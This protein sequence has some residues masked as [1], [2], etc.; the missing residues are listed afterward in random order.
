MSFMILSLALQD[1]R[2]GWRGLASTFSHVKKT[3]PGAS[4]FTQYLATTPDTPPDSPDREQYTE[5]PSDLPEEGKGTPG[6]YVSLTKKDYPTSQHIHYSPEDVQRAWFSRYHEMYQ[7]V[8]LREIVV[9]RNVRMIQD[10]PRFLKVE[11]S[12]S[13]KQAHGEDITEKQ[14]MLYHG[15]GLEF[16]T[17]VVPQF[18]VADKHGQGMKDTEG[19]KVVLL[20]RNMFDFLEKLTTFVL[21]RQVANYKISM[22]QLVDSGDHFQL[23]FNVPNIEHFPEYVPTLDLF[24]DMR[25]LDVTLFIEGA[26]A[27]GGQTGYKRLSRAKQRQNILVLLQGLAI[28][29]KP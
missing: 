4:G 13:A 16:I 3:I 15:L 19:V 29:I 27:Q 9:K 24:E 8:V 22:K 6:M 10:L 12:I 26:S 2:S 25:Q 18:I 23:T 17:G 7:N 5:A 11:L 28:P 14:N 21:P 20:G 1:L